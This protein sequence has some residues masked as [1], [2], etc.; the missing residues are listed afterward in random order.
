MFAFITFASFHKSKSTAME[1]V[2][3]TLKYFPFSKSTIIVDLFEKKQI[4]WR[5]QFSFPN[6]IDEDIF[7]FTDLFGNIYRTI[8]GNLGDLL[9]CFEK[10]EHHPYSKEGIENARQRSREGKSAEVLCK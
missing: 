8:P 9:R 6:A 1:L 3:D 7:I 2:G 4:A 10:Q 5:F